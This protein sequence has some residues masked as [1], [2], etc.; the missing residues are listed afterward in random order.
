GVTEVG[1]H[2]THRRRGLLRQLMARMLA[3]ARTRGEAFAGLIASES[4]IYGRFG[5]GH[6]TSAG[7]GCID[8]PGRGMLEP[9]P[10]LDIRLVDAEE[11]GKVLPELFDGQRRVRAGEPNR[12]ALQWEERLSDRPQ[13]RRGAHALFHAVCEEGY[14]SY[15]VHEQD[16][17]RGERHRLL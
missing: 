12:N 13:R 3:D 9:A 6:A 7:D 2:P 16:I 11:A 15:R 10:R 14:V 1:V 4:V 8:S 17:L 5:F